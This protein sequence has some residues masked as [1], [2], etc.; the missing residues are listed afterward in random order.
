MIDD[1]GANREMDEVRII[2]RRKKSY[3]KDKKKEKEEKFGSL[4]E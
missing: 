1:E 3:D 4:K 2:V